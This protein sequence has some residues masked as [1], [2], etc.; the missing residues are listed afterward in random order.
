M[1]EA[2]TRLGPWLLHFYEAGERVMWKC[3]LYVRSLDD[4]VLAGVRRQHV[5]L[6]WDISLGWRRGSL[7]TPGF[8]VL[9]GQIQNTLE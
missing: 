1:D 4:V 5:L 8:H 9:T 7:D 6:F 3:H 2:R